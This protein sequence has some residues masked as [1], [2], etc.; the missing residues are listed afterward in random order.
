MSIAGEFETIADAVYD[1]GKQDEYDRFWDSFQKNGTLRF[2]GNAF[3]GNGWNDETFNPKYPIVTDVNVNR[4]NN[5]FVYSQITKIMCPLY[6]YDSTSISTFANNYSLTKIGDDTGGGIWVTRN[7]TWASNFSGCT[8]LEE[9][10]F[11]DYNEK[12]E[13]VPSE[14]GNSIDFKNCTLLSVDS[15]VNI[16][17][18]LVDYSTESTGTYTLTLHADAWTRLEASEKTPQTEGIDFTGTWREYVSS[19]GWT[20]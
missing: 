20:T 17:K 3:S 2:Y 13:Y 14:I 5:V 4:S 15:Q 7:R 18:H 8:K 19:L 11:I 16:I 12:G 10:R 6:F 9:V 1:K